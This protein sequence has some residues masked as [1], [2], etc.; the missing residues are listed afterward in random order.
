[1]SCLHYNSIQP[2]WIFTLQLGCDEYSVFVSESLDLSRNR[3][4]LECYDSRNCNVSL[5][6]SNLPIFVILLT[7]VHT[8]SVVEILGTIAVSCAPAM[9]A[10]WLKIFTKS[11]LWSKLQSSFIFSYLRSQFLSLNMAD[12]KP[13]FV[14]S[15]RR[16]PS[17]EENRP[18]DA[19]I[20]SAY[21]LKK[22][23]YDV[24][25]DEAFMRSS[26]Q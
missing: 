20:N 17:S 9:S 12:L 18:A 25:R 10:F 26:N 11:S 21:I 22:T 1:M 7:P 15:S 24:L 3:L 4:D 5:T 13:S 14:F 8:T 23:T 19:Q 2:F 16:S 6:N